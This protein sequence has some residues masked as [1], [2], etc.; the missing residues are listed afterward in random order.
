MDVKVQ[1]SEDCLAHGGNQEYPNGWIGTEIVPARIM[2]RA[3]S[4]TK[5][6]KEYRNSAPYAQENLRYVRFSDH[7]MGRDDRN[8]PARKTDDHKGMWI[9]AWLLESA[10]AATEKIAA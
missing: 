1:L 5:A 7:F 2:S 8:R 4:P 6:E 10:K 3:I 9:P